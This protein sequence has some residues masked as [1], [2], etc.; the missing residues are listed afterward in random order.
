MID[1]D[2]P[3]SLGNFPKHRQKVLALATAATSDPDVLG[4]TIKGSFATGNPDRFSDLDL[5]FVIRDDRFELALDRRQDLVRAPAEPIAAFTAEHLHL[6]E[7]LVTLYDDLISADIRYVPL[8]HFPDPKED[9]PCRVLWQ[10]D[11]ILSH[12]LVAATA[13]E[14]SID[15]A[16]IEARMWTWVWSTHRKILR[17]EVYE[18]LDAL[19]FLRSNVLFP[20]LSVRRGRPPAGSRRAEQLVG[21]LNKEFLQTIAAADRQ[22]TMQALQ[23]TVDL[24]LH[25]VDPLLDQQN[26]RKAERARQR[27]LA[28]LSEGLGFNP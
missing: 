15:V 28:A 11:D 5:S 9:L 3:T 14:P 1:M 10:R 7:L 18:A 25:L 19:Q 6:P 22:E 17:G 26:V 24:Y 13:P 20:L 4:V 12:R 2:M 27:V 23:Q 16:H 21:D 8:R